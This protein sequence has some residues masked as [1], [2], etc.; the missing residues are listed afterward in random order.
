MP[1]LRG[2]PLVSFEE[3]AS[4][5]RLLVQVPRHLKARISPEQARM[6]LRERLE[7]RDQRFLELMRRAVYGN[8]TSPY[9]VLLEAVGCEYGDLAGCVRRDGIE[10]AL[11]TLYRQG[12]YLTADELKGRRPVVRGS[13]ILSI[14]PDLLRN[15]LTGPHLSVRSSGSRSMGTLVI[16]DLALFEERRVNQALVF[17]AYGAFGWRHALW[18]APGGGAVLRLLRYAGSGCPPVRWFS[19]VDITRVH[20]RYRWS[21]R[22]LSWGARVAGVRMPAPEHVPLD[23]VLPIARWMHEVVRSGVPAHFHGSPSAA[24]RVC[25][26]AL[27]HGLDVTGAHFTVSGEPLTPARQAV[28][29]RAGGRAFTAYTS[30]ETGGPVAYGC[31]DPDVGDDVHLWDDLHAIIQ[32]GVDGRPGGRA[33]TVLITTLSPTSPLVLL[34]AS[35]GD[36]AVVT[37][38]ECGCPL[39]QLGWTTHLHTIRSF[40]KLTGI[41]VTF[42][43]T[44]VVRVLEEVL[45][46]RFG[47]SP[48][49]YQLIETETDDGQPHLRL[50]VHPAVGPVDPDTVR[51]AFLGAIA[52][53]S[54]GEQLMG[55]MWRDGRVVTV[56]RSAPQATVSGKIMHLHLQR[57]AAALS[58]GRMPMMTRDSAPSCSQGTTAPRT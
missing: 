58:G 16:V 47:G 34:N 17:D 21:A 52:P 48:T 9:A 43:D 54:A 28:I 7:A 25:L 41:G 4:A 23:D 37:R 40:E 12:V 35:M 18:G 14:H 46:A 6:V 42:L 51:D 27:E 45:P 13:T 31:L 33:G 29:A 56:E 20:A 11:G 57:P 24:V 53:G 19:P 50:L 55:L 30:M 49:H 44:D 26:A 2:H 3:A 15:P 36:E 39:Q 5:L 8:P 38:R 1:M 10:G 22:I 32:P